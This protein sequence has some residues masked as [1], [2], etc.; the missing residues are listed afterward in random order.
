VGRGQSYWLLTDLLTFKVT[1]AD[2]NG[3][4]TVLEV[5]AG[6]GAGPPPHIHRECDESFYILEG[7]FEFTLAGQPFKAGVGEFVYLPKGV[8]HTHQSSGGVPAKAL[9][10]QTPSGVEHF[11]AEAGKAATDPTTRPVPTPADVERVLGLAPK[12]GI[13]VVV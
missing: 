12:H 6:P 3:A 9:A 7:T 10:M 11:V 4:M 1:G 8:L 5:A 13:D 2:T